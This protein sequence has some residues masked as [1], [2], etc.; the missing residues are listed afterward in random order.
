[1][2]VGNGRMGS[3]IWFE[4]DEMHMQWNRSDVFANDA[5]TQSF[6][7]ESSDYSAG[8]GIIDLSLGTGE[9]AVFTEAIRQQLSVYDGTYRM[10]ADQVTIETF[11]DMDQ[12]ICYL[13]IQDHRENP[14]K[15]RLSLRTLRGGCMYVT[16]TLSQIHPSLYKK[17]KSEK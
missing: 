17:E 4:R 2:P 9:D 14:Q 3:L 15:I 13:H 12:D 5:T 16:G 7:E 8:T 1:M 11:M 10:E 6:R